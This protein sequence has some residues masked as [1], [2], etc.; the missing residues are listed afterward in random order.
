MLTMLAPMRDPRTP[1]V[2]LLSEDAT[3]ELGLGT[4]IAPLHLGHLVLAPALVGEALILWLQCTH[5]NRIFSASISM[6]WSLGILPCSRRRDR[7]PTGARNQPVHHG[8]CVDYPSAFR[9]AILPRPSKGGKTIDLNPSVQRSPG[10]S[11][12]MHLHGWLARPAR[13]LR[14][15]DLARHVRPAGG[16]AVPGYVAGL[17]D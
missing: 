8:P 10:S 12:A 17:G 9:P 13:L 6:F 5:T 11:C 7:H 2:I 3:T 15:C 16:R 4:V 14:G 1:I